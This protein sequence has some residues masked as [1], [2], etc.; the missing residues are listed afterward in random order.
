M[1]A[2]NVSKTLSNFVSYPAVLGH[3]FVGSIVELG[4]NV[5]NFSIGDRV[6]I[7]PII[8]CEVRGL[9]PCDSC[10]TVILIYVQIWMEVLFLQVH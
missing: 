5:D 1:L 10:K 3:E 8:A 9:E 2:L 6:A 4:K 7:E